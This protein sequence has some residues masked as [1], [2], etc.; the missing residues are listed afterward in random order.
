MSK[1]CLRKSNYTKV[2]LQDVVGKAFNTITQKA[3]V[4]KSLGVQDQP[5]FILS[6]NNFF[7]LNNFSEWTLWTL[8]LSFR[9]TVYD[10]MVPG[11]CL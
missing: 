3:E 8:T 2:A 9:D 11:L 1:K 7:Y 6:Q 5:K 10:F 4:G